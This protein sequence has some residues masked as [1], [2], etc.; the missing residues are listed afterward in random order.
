MPLALHNKLK[1]QAKKKGI[2][3]K[4]RNAFIFGTLAKIE[5]KKK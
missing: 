2:L 3:G 4:R 5:K 1:K